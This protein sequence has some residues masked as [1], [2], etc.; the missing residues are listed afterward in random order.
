[1]EE[2]LHTEIGD[3]L[4]LV[5]C[6]APSPPSRSQAECKAPAEESEDRASVQS[7]EGWWIWGGGVAVRTHEGG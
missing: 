6:W 2:T 3:I 7:P 1:M 4:S 5:S